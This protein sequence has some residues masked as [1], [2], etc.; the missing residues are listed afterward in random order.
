MFNAKDQE[1]E[2]LGSLNE[3]GLC[4]D[5]VKA[6]TQILAREVKEILTDSQGLKKMIIDIII[7]ESANIET[8]K[9]AN[10]NTYGNNIID[11]F[12]NLVAFKDE[13]LIN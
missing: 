8:S 9:L 13:F 10:A 1:T 4:I 11:N 12:E 6:G 2:E 3:Y 5:F 7:S